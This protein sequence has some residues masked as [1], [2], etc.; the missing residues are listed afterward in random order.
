MKNAKSTDWNLQDAKA[1]L[2]ELVDL[3]AA[4]RPQVILRR[5]QATAAIVSIDDYSRLKGRS[6]SLV[7][8]LLHETPNLEGLD[9]ER[10]T[11]TY[12]PRVEF[13]DPHN[14]DKQR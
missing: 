6:D 4:G 2:S 1:R 9:F 3:A 7:S 14:A 8:F 11:E 12:E 5:G 10:S 13:G